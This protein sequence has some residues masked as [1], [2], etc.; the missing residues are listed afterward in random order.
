[1]VST[2]CGRM[3][4]F[5]AFLIV[6]L[7]NIFFVYVLI[8]KKNYSKQEYKNYIFVSGIFGPLIDLAILIFIIIFIIIFI[9]EKKCSR[10]SELK[11]ILNDYDNVVIKT[12]S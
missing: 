7:A 1:M 2:Y 12:L 3:P 6:I 4:S 8:N 11:E 10:K 9:C 5:L